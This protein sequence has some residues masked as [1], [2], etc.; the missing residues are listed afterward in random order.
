[1]VLAPHRNVR[2]SS[3]L[4]A[5]VLSLCVRVSAGGGGGGGAAASCKA[6]DTAVPM[7]F[8][9]DGCCFDVIPG[10]S[11]EDAH[12]FLNG[13]AYK[14][15][16]D[17]HHHHQEEDHDRNLMEWARRVLGGESTASDADFMPY[18]HMGGRAAHGVRLQVHPCPTSLGFVASIGLL[19]TVNV[20]VCRLLSAVGQSTIVG[21]ILAGMAVSF[22][23]ERS[24][25]TGSSVSTDEMAHFSELGILLLLFMAGLEVSC[26]AVAYAASSSCCHHPTARSLGQRR[27][28]CRAVSS[29][30]SNVHMH[31]AHRPP[32]RPDG[33]TCPPRTP[34]IGRALT[35]MCAAVCAVR[36][37]P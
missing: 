11:A 31:D 5:T 36:A 24:T 25:L 33:S 13:H 26:E 10:G 1:M 9:A 19:F 27:D 28:A 20:V 34:R 12:A 15:L 2:A 6:N 14:G 29:A 30:P 17:H 23:A 35:R 7:T 32:P 3:F 4:A 37:A 8:E 18:G 21:Y 16:P 22:A